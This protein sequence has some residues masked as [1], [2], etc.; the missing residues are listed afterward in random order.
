MCRLGVGFFDELFFE[1]RDVGS[2]IS[3]APALVWGFVGAF[4][5]CW[6]LEPQPDRRAADTS[7]AVTAEAERRGRDMGISCLGVM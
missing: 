6:S 3:A 2:L 1:G 7:K 5:S 4:A